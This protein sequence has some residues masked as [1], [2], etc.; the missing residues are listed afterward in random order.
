M[1]IAS[2]IAAFA[3]AAFSVVASAAS[4]PSFVPV[5]QQNFP[6]PFVLPHGA[7]FIAYSTNDGPNVPIATSRDLVHWSFVTDQSGQKLD[8]LP[9]LGS[10]AKAGFTW[11]PEVLQLGDRYLLYYTASDRRKSAQCVGVAVAA[12]PH[13][14]FVDSAAEPLI[15]QTK[16]GG[17]IDAD[18]FR[19]SDGKLYLY[20]KNDGNRVHQRTWLWGQRLG[21]DGLSTVGEPVQLLGDKERWKDAVIEAPTMVRGPAGYALFY[22]AGFFGWNPGEGGLSP[23]AMGYA[24]CSTPLGPCKDSPDNPM[25]HSFYDRE[26]G[27]L[28]GPGHQS[29][30]QARGRMFVSFHAW[31]ATPYCRKE[32]DKRVLYVAP[33]F[34]NQGKPTLG[35]SLRAQS[36][37]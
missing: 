28:S 17:T 9:R 21:E 2:S 36:P 16:L 7:E 1:R 35:P 31:A 10:W 6:D 24:S 13:G 4:S 15:C 27:C 12:D 26:A 20:F 34:W 29:I 5:M 23:Y 32:G 8:A 22:S 3:A 30:F 33:L 37:H 19:D 14:P 18:A 25:L 11:A